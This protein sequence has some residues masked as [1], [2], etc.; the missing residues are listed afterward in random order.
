MNS[1]KLAL[2]PLSAL[3]LAMAAPLASAEKGDWFMHL[4]AIQIAPDETP[5]AVDINN[6]LAPD[7]SI[8]YF[9]TEHFALDL[10]LTVPQKHTVS[11][12]G[13]PLGDFKQLPPTLLGQWHFNPRGKDRPYIGAGVNYTII[14]DEQLGGIKLD[15]SAGPAAQIGMDVMLDDK[16]SVSFDN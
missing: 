6:K 2:L 10:L 7:L 16:W 8:G 1:K 11:L 14:S 3:A 9:V 4:R 12:N 15:N 5:D 13:A